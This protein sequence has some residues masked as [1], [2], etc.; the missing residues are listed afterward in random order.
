M[1][2]DFG[3]KYVGKDTADHLIQALKN[4]YTISIDWTGSL[5]CGITINWDYGKSICD[6]SMPTY[7]QEALQKFQRPA[8]SRPKDTPHTWNQ[9]VYGAAV[10]YADQPNDSPL[11]PPKSINI[12]QQIIGTL[13]YY[14]IAVD[15]NM[16]VAIGAIASQQPKDTQT[17]LD[18]NVWILNYAAPHPNATIRYSASDM[19]LHL[20]SDA[21]YLSEPG[22][23]SRVG[24]HY[25]L[26]N[27][28]TDPTNPPLTESHL[29]GPIHTVSKI[30]HNVMAS[31]AEAE[32]G[33]TFHNG[34]EAVPIRTNLQEL[35]P[36]QP[37]T[38]IRVNNST[39]EG[40]ANGTIK[41]KTSKAINVHLI[42][43]L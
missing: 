30:L 26:G 31:A 32:I 33:D 29:N 38:P 37:P 43:P 23:R 18:A 2:D 25:S 11:L 22:A 40:F 34:Q 3:V 6:I 4:L 15:H 8:P 5:Y 27:K 12:V 10:Q 1:V 36:L 42:I 20:H 19:V 16:L 39:A 14:A 35:G 7:I 13:L 24:G 28:S 9:P 21:S 17:T 41:Q